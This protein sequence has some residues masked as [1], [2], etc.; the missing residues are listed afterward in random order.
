MR[1]GS[2]LQKVGVTLAGVVVAFVLLELALRLIGLVFTGAQDRRNQVALEPDAG[3]VI[4]AVG[5]STTAFGGDDAWPAQLE[6]IL[7]ERA[8]EAFTVVNEGIPGTDSSVIVAQLQTNLDRYR[9][10]VVVAMMGAN[11]TDKG[12]VPFLEQPRAEQTGFVESLRTVRLARQLLHDSAG[13]TAA[14]GASSADGIGDDPRA[15]VD[16][17]RMLVEAYR[18]A[19]A[20]Q[21]L[22]RSLEIDRANEAAHVELGKMYETLARYAEAEAAFLAGIEACPGCSASQ[23]ELARHYERQEENERAADAF[24]RALAAHPNDAKAWFGLGRVLR[25]MEAFEEGTA[26]FERVIEIDP[27]NGEAYVS[28]GLCL[29]GTG[30]QERAGTM[31]QE[32]WRRNQDRRSFIRLADFLERQ[33]QHAQLLALIEEGAARHQDDDDILGR[34]A[35]YHR[36]RGNVE[37]AVMYQSAA[38]D[39]RRRSTPGM[40]RGNYHRMKAVT[41]QHGVAL[42]A[43]QYPVR[44]LDSLQ[45]IFAGM[46]GVVFVDNEAS[47]REALAELAYDALFWHNCYGDFGHCTQAGNRLLAENVAEVLLAEVF[48]G[49]EE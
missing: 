49:V 33:D 2:H 36:R 12:A 20:E 40:T 46:E 32:G 38:D 30:D 17:G 23:V 16:R 47:F 43:V 37:Q 48:G 6:G 13:G 14:E 44:S 29:E 21:V 4:L 15:L 3:R 9:P 41:D 27:R 42:V 22:L 45:A 5:E 24:R 1:I 18:Y 31:L 39:A 26:A 8:G 19:E 11:D 25:K 7:E 35:L 28:L 34:A 10:E